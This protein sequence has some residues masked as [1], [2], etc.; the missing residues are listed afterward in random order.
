[1]NTNAIINSVKKIAANRQSIERILQV[2]IALGLLIFLISYISI[3]ELTAAFSM[4]EYKFVLY[5]SLLSIVNIFLQAYKWKLVVNQSLGEVPLRRMFE[6]FFSGVTSGL[7]TPAR[8]GEFIGRAI[9]LKEFNFFKVTIVSFIDKIINILVITF[10]GA[11]SSV[12][13]YRSLNSRHFYIDI[14]LLTV[15]VILF[16]LITYMLFSNGFFTALIKRKFKNNEKVLDKISVVDSF[17]SQDLHKKLKVF[18]VNIIFFF[19]ILVQF[20]LLVN[21][22]TEFTNYFQLML[23]ASLILFATTVVLPFSFGDLG[24]REGAASYLVGLVAVAPA[25]GFNAAIILFMINVILP[26]LVGLIFLFMKK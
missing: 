20:T 5:A 10:F 1:M 8:I 13:F 4:A 19:I 25:V 22:F 7:S 6:S 23:I 16:C 17:V 26:A 2:A 15:I 9:P 11:V 21:A 3:D 12:L 14:P 18:G 24:V